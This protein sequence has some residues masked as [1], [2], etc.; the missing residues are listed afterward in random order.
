VVE[1]S[2][3]AAP[4]STNKVKRLLTRNMLD[5][6]LSANPQ[7]A[8]K[9]YEEMVANF[10][11][12]REVAAQAIL[13]LGESYRRMG[14][15][16]EARALYAR[17]LREFV[18]FPEL[19]K[20][21]QR[22]LSENAPAPSRGD[23]DSPYT[24]PNSDEQD[25]IKQELSLL[26]KHLEENEALVKS[27]LASPSSRFSLQREIL[28][29]RQRLARAKSPTQTAS[30]TPEIPATQAMNV[31]SSRALPGEHS[32]QIQQLQTELADLQSQMSVLSSHKQP[33]TI[34]TQVISDPRF[35]E[36]KA[37][38]ETKLL[39]GS[40]NE[41]S[42]KALDA[43]RE[44]LLRWVE[45]IYLPELKNTIAIKSSRLKELEEQ[46]KLRRR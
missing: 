34:S 14:R 40:G 25:L 28:Q 41:E 42:K 12:Q 46:S 4:P 30:T 44:R 8:A 5:E 32:K 38:F 16:D 19:A 33:D 43:A 21:S 22:L 27:G 15:I 29:L 6:E 23:T 26:E 37:N 31:F 36:L 20:M 9:K 13:R 1:P 18:D 2:P 10:D 17:I 45:Q 3:A 7:A 35:A 11:Q 39:D 24:V